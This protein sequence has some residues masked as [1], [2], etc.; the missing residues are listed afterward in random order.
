[1][2]HIALTCPRLGFTMGLAVSRPPGR[3]VDPNA[4]VR[5]LE[6]LGKTLRRGPNDQWLVLEVG[7]STE[8]VLAWHQLQPLVVQDD[9]E[10]VS[11]V[12]STAATDLV[13]G[14]RSEPAMTAA[15]VLRDLVDVTDF[16]SGCAVARHFT[17]LISHAVPAAIAEHR[18]PAAPL[19]LWSV[20]DGRIV[21]IDRDPCIVGRAPDA[22]LQIERDYVS[23]QHFVFQRSNDGWRMRDLPSSSGTFVNGNRVDA[24]DLAPGMV[25]QLA[26]PTA[27]VVLAVHPAR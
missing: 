19:V 16:S 4:L 2:T 25:I 10:I 9:V 8:A 22:G 11:I 12:G 17:R 13:F 21:T 24:M 27:F 18:L 26:R 1:M 7:D 14:D 5:A 20:A 15:A 3:L 6:P 23:R